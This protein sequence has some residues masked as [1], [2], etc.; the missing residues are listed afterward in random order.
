MNLPEKNS[1]LICPG[2]GFQVF[3]RRYP[4]CEAC[5]NLLP[6]SLVLSASERAE[7]QKKEAQEE[8]GKQL[9]KPRG[10]TA[11]GGGDFY[12]LDGSDSSGHCGGDGGAGG[13]GGGGG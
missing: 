9:S 5:G 13:D 2:C 1:P 12:V 8:R 6:K 4:R 3:N 7:L 10:S 11:G